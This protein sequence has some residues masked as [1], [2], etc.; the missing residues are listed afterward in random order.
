MARYA[1]KATVYIQLESDYANGVGEAQYEIE[2]YVNQLKN[3]TAKGPDGAEVEIA[4]AI[5]IK[6][7]AGELQES[8]GLSVDKLWHIEPYGPDGK[9]WKKLLDN[10][11][12]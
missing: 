12:R 7:L 11:Y 6:I 10:G 1:A 5:D 4:R 3:L 8:P 9:V 2:W